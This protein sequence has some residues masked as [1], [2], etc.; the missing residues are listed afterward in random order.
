MKLREI[1]KGQ[2][3]KPDLFEKNVFINSAMT[4]IASNSDNI[5]I[6]PE[7]NDSV[8]AELITK[9][10]EQYAVRVISGRD[11]FQELLS[12]I[13]P[14]DFVEL[15]GVED[16]SKLS[17]AHYRIL[18]IENILKI[19]DKNSW[20]LC[21]NQDFIYAFNGCHWT[22]IDHAIIK[23]FLGEAAE[24]MG[25]QWEKSRDYSFRKSLFEQFLETANFIN[26]EKKDSV[27]IPLQN[28]TYEINNGLRTLREFDRN[29]FITYQ[30]P[31]AYDPDAIA[32]RFEK[33]LG[34]VLPDM[35]R[36][37][38]I[39]E[40]LGYLF[41]RELK[42][43]KA[44][45]LYGPGANGKSV[46]FEVITALLG[47]N[48]VGNFSL[49]S[50]TDGHGYYRA[51]LANKLVNYASEING[52]LQASIFKQIVSGEP[53]EA[54]LP[55]GNP[56][57]ISNY[58]KLIFNTNTL[59]HDVEHTNA[60]FRRFLIVPF[61][62]TIKSEDQDVELSRKIIQSELPGVFN[63]VLSGLD[64]LLKN[65]KFTDCKAVRDQLESYRKHSDSV[66]MFLEDEGYQKSITESIRLKELYQGFKTYCLDS[67]YRPCSVRTFSERLRNLG[68]ETERKRD[69]YVVYISK[70]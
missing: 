36:Q 31:F 65:K 11:I 2:A 17:N 25:L 18:T 42:L 16:R 66:A 63:W 39:A 9:D 58:A 47:A 15:A 38:V 69:G 27:L 26:P 68:F 46:M 5:N 56:M 22:L 52:N 64:R 13:T 23:T 8:F 50:L 24:R 54:R 59:P 35:D 10:A 53:V 29:D 3:R 7:F 70:A 34:E 51:M 67:G 20:G 6:S 14:I 60:F 55:Y 33:Y 45:I 49:S 28:G 48:N 19:A 43:E 32:P 37:L 1:E 30:L 12:Q 40:Y 61:D 41:T 4:K 62:V 57:I 21:R 44:L